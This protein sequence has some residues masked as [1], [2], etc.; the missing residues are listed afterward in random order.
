M[1]ADFVEVQ[2]IRSSEQVGARASET[3]H[4]FVRRKR[5]QTAA[6]VFRRSVRESDGR[7]AAVQTDAP[8]D[9]GSERS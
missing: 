9:V 1:G 7:M 8:V 6:G 4:V 3:D 2:S 5:R